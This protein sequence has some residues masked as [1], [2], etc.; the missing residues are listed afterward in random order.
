MSLITARHSDSILTLEFKDTVSR[1]SFSVRAAEELCAICEK[2]AGRVRGVIFSAPG[3]VFCS[4]GNLADYAAMTSADPGK[5]VNRRITEILEHVSLLPVPTVC[6]VEGDCFGGGLELISAFDVVISAPAA[7][8]GFWQRRIGLTFGWGGGARLIRRLGEQRVKQ[9][10][11]KAAT[12]GA[13]EAHRVG[14]IDAVVMEAFLMEE[15][16][17]Q[18]SRMSSLPRAP[19]SSIKSFEKEREQAVFEKLWWNE[20]HRAVL[21]LRNQGARRGKD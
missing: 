15:A 2:E 18:I 3:R 11:L 10:A 21:A 16:A 5:D 12:F 1:N 9:Y 17:Q 14:L 4:G 19:L 6:V 20:E 13:L 7:L 8:F